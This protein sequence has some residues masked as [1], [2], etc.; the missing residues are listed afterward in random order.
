MNKFAPFAALATLATFALV[1]VAV[2][3]QDGVPAKAAEGKMVYGA[4]G[5]R[6]APVYRV[7]GDGSV[8]LIMEGRLVTIPATVL[9][10]VNGKLTSSENKAELLR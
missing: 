1:P 7:N 10:D 8:Q 4:N 3:A 2:H 5:Q 9:S 6:L